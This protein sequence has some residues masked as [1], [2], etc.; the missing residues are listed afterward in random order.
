MIKAI[1]T[2]LDGTIVPTSG[3]ICNATKEVLGA[4]RTQGV[5]VIPVTGRSYRDA[6]MICKEL[7]WYKYGIYYGGSKIINHLTQRSIWERLIDS[8]IVNE[9]LTSAK[10]Y[11]ATI[12][13]EVIRSDMSYPG[14]WIEVPLVNLDDMLNF[15][16]RFNSIDTALNS[17]SY[18]SHMGIQVTHTGGT[19]YYGA[20][21][22]IDLLELDSEEV[23]AIGDGDNDIPLFEAA[24]CT[25]AMGNGTDT[26]KS[27]ANFITDGIDQDGFAKAIKRYVFK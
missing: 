1:F 23:L 12:S 16:Q 11:K 24:G 15:L 22:L 4:L 13:P 20:K 21:Y 8:T 19:K 6:S 5:A 18:P 10:K 9:V 3:R 25:I 27:K 7:R 26:L 17:A 2:E 14:L